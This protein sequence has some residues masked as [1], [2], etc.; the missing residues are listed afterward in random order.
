MTKKPSFT[1][2]MQVEGI[3]SFEKLAVGDLE[4]MIQEGKIQSAYSHVQTIEEFNGVRWNPF[5]D[6]E[7]DRE[8]SLLFGKGILSLQQDSLG[9]LLQT[10][11][12]YGNNATVDTAFGEN[13]EDD[14]ECSQA[15]QIA[16]DTLGIDPKK[17]SPFLAQ[18]VIHN[19]TSL[20]AFVEKWRSAQKQKPRWNPLYARPLQREKL[21]RFIGTN[22]P[23]KWLEKLGAA[24][25]FSRTEREQDI[26][27]GTDLG[28]TTTSRGK[29][30]LL[31]FDGWTLAECLRRSY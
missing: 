28:T 9:E 19:S 15:L 29:Y 24:H 17:D 23:E 8:Y 21:Y 18:A 2:I 4:R 7:S 26:E 5:H 3:A 31:P 27:D 14:Q 11:N 6:I 20:I 22:Q 25:T 30:L 13:L 12:F 1:K 10:L 16:K